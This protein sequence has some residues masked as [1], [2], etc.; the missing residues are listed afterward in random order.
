MVGVNVNNLIVIIFYGVECEIEDGGYVFML[1]FG[2]QFNVF[3]KFFNEDVVV[4]LNY[5]LKYYGNLELKVK[6]E[7]VVVICE[8][9]L[10]LL[11]LL[12]V[13]IGMGVGVVVVVLLLLLGVLMLL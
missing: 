11:L 2:D 10:C 7:D 4:L 8:G 13:C 5:L 1:F 9:G 3:N 6:F 12:V